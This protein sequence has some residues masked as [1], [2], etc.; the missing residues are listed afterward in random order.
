MN[1]SLIDNVDKLKGLDI[2]ESLVFIR[3]TEDFL[4]LNYNIIHKCSYFIRNF[5]KIIETRKQGQEFDDDFKHLTH[6]LRELYENFKI[7]AKEFDYFNNIVNTGAIPKNSNPQRLTMHLKSVCNDF[8]T[9]VE[10]FS[11]LVEFI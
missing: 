4:Q 10:R 2:S 11:R 3:I 6:E 9:N 8:E 5:S 1:H 7:I